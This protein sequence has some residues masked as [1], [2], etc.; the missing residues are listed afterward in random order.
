MLSILPKIKG[1]EDI[2]RLDSGELEVLAREIRYV[3]AQTVSKNGGHLGS[4]LGVVEL[5]ISL[6]LSFSSPKD[7]IL[8]DVGH[9]VYAHKLLTGRFERFS[10][11]RQRGG[12]SGYP[13][14]SESPHDQFI[15]GHASTAISAA[16]GMACARDLKKENHH[17][18][19]VVGDGSLTGGMSFEAMNHAGQKG[20]RLIIVLN[21]NG[22]FISQRVGALASYLNRIRTHP[23]YHK[24]KSDLEQMILRLP[25][26]GENVSRTVERLKDSLKYLVVPGMFFE[27]LGFRYFG[28]I[29]G[30]DISSMTRTFEAAKH[31]KG[32]TLVHVVTQ[33]GKGYPPAEN[34][35]SRF[36]GI[37][38][39]D[40]A[41]GESH[42]GRHAPTYSQ[43]FGEAMVKLGSMEP[44][45]V[46]IT[47][48]MVEGTGLTE[49]S[50]RF[51][52]RFFD[53]G[54]AEQHAVTFAAGL[55]S[56]GMRPVLAVYSTFLQRAYDQLVHDV[57]LPGAG[58]VFALDR[59]GIVGEDGPTHQGAFDLSYLGHIPNMSI[60]VPADGYELCDMLYTAVLH[61]SSPTAIR[62]P[63][64][65]VPEGFEHGVPFKEIPWGKA[66][67]LRDGTDL[68]IWAYGPMVQEALLAADELE[69]YGIYAT[70]VNG[71][72]VKPLDEE[73]LRDL[74]TKTDAF[75]VVE[76]NV[77]SG[78]A[79]SRILGFLHDSASA[80][81]DIP[82]VR[83]LGLPDRFIEHGKREEVLGDLGLDARG[84]VAAA[85]KLLEPSPFGLQAAQMTP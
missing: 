37:G 56:R 60:A 85:L 2:R 49:F 20:S 79:A 84:I 72:F 78:G 47:A 22:M 67:V 25:F 61:R 80:G 54:I 83:C 32:P 42:S 41:T 66:V 55:A 44:R 10:S 1:P 26:V 45:L 5:T 3:I 8:W 16:L 19:A 13:D 76:E 81:A 36:H 30:H 39:F 69:R 15:A 11:L 57:A 68:V 82:K 21:D 46:A 43:V 27:E 74:R 62:Y 28:P 31:E 63:K 50:R 70:V 51:P 52:E 6:H 14:P 64:S 53:V 65:R 77:T 29:N 40:L 23:A 24:V 75:L 38:P 35:P 59:A 12:L 7:I 18:V 33:K 58:V 4:N 71:R 73:L 9:Q 48:A 34:D 17:V